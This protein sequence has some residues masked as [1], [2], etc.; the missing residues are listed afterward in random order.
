MREERSRLRAQVYLL[1]KER[2]TSEAQHQTHLAQIKLL[3]T[4]M[5]NHDSS[6]L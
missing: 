4:Q 5:V 1:E 3:Q 6:N 2:A